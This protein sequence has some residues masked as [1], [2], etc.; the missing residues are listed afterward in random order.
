MLPRSGSLSVSIR[1]SLS[2]ALRI[3][4][5][6]VRLH[7][8]GAGAVCTGMTASQC[9]VRGGASASRS[10]RIGLSR[11]AQDFNGAPQIAEF[12]HILELVEPEFRREVRMFVLHVRFA[13]LVGGVRGDVIGV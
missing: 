1:K 10:L 8:D 13:I 12:D 7:R 9:T 4:Q 2:P 6:I 5:V 3:F 11:T